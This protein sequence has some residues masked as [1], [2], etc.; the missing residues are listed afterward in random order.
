[1]ASN[2]QYILEAIGEIKK[3]NGLKGKEKPKT[4]LGGTITCP[5][6]GNKLNYT[7]SKVNCHIWGQCE[8]VKCLSWMM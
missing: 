3:I 8:T 1:M 5:I 4:N 6:C 2:I 7:V